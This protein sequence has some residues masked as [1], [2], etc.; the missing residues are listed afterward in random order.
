VDRDEEGKITTRVF[1]SE[2]NSDSMLKILGFK[3]E[4]YITSEPKTEQETAVLER[5]EELAET[6]I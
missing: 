4:S 6:K 1:A 2:Q 5:E 3:D